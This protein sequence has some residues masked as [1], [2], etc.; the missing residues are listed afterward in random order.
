MVLCDQPL[1]VTVFLFSLDNPSIKR[2]ACLCT[3]SLQELKIYH[4][5]NMVD[6]THFPKTR[7]SATLSFPGS[8]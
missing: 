5:P 8:L 1:Q 7:L 4:F 6:D 3:T 2:K